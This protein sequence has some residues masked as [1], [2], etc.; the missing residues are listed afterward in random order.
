LPV[1][2]LRTERVQAVVAT[3]LALLLL[4]PPPA[5]AAPPVALSPEAVPARVCPDGVL[6]V[7]GGDAADLDDACTG[8]AAALAFLARHGLDAPPRIDIEIV[9][10]MPAGYTPDAA[11]CFDPSR[12]LVLLLDYTGFA[13]FGTWMGRPIDR[14]MHR[15]IAAHEVA[16]AL[17]GC[18]F[19]MRRP[20]R[21]AGEYIAFV[22]MFATM[23]P[24]LRDHALAVHPDPAWPDADPPTPAQYDAQPMRFG[25]QAWRH[26]LMQPDPAATLR[27]ILEGRVLGG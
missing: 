12:A 1:K 22:T 8:G 27:G 5:R 18:H 16:H 10:R 24:A 26:W 2:R 25:A 14:A 6:S 4:A 7:R 3:A 20:S 23:D 13:R 15:A 17:S 21:I 19:A 9:A 11:G